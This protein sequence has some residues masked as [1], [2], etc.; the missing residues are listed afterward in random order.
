MKYLLSF[1]FLLFSFKSF[2]QIKDTLHKISPRNMVISFPEQEIYK[3]VNDYL[4]KFV[5][6]DL[7]GHIIDSDFLIGKPTVV[8]FWFTNCAPCIEEMPILN[9]IKRQYGNK[10][11]FVA[12]TFQEANV[13][14]DFLKLNEF[15]FL[16]IVNS[17]T[18]LK[19]F[20]FFSYPKTIILDDNLKVIKI[21]RLIGKNQNSNREN[22]IEFEKRISGILNVL[23]ESP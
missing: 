20:G 22:I 7:D 2:C 3:Y 4:P 5:L 1:L 9:K 21:E 17:K 14:K 13:V 6:T 19:N 23:L 12:M 10:I 16:Q 8:N 18:Y 15:D 11:N